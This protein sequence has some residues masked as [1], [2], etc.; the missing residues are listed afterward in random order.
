MN[1]LE[2]RKRGC[3]HKNNSAAN[4]FRQPLLV[5]NNVKA[6]HFYQIVHLTHFL[7]F[8]IININQNIRNE[9]KFWKI[10]GVYL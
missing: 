8:S 5:P 10:K 7:T 2:N 6:L 3:T 9:R 1:T 4:Y